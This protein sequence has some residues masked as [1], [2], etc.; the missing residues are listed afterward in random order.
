MWCCSDGSLSMGSPQQL[1]LPVGGGWCAH[2]PLPAPQSRV[3]GSSRAPQELSPSPGR[4]DVLAPATPAWELPE[5]LRLLLGKRSRAASELPANPSPHPAVRG[6][7]GQRLPP[8]KAGG[9]TGVLPA[10]P[11]PRGRGAPCPELPGALP[12]PSVTAIQLGSILISM[13]E[14]SCSLEGKGDLLF[15][16]DGPTNRGI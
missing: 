13:L 12:P 14:C 1:S 4:D 7:P 3:L 2:D 5:V 8:R 16:G 15:K 11:Q 10:P 6:G 9:G